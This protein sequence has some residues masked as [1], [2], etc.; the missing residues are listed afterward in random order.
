MFTSRAEYRL[1]LRHDNA[2][3]RLTPLGRRIG[4]VGDRAWDRLQAKEKAI[5]EV[6]E[7]LRTHR[8]GPDSL[9]R[10]LRR[11]EVEWTDLCAWVPA[12]AAMKLAADIVEQ[13]VL[14]LKYSGYIDRQAAQ[15]E[16]F[17]RLESR[18]IPA[19]FDYDAI[20]QLRFEAREKL[21]RIRP[22][23]VGQASRISGI[24]AADLAVILM[25]LKN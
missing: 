4:L 20:P 10:W 22:L 11:T 15:V 13:V 24:H 8:H 21:S 6:M 19:S 5:A 16:R 23:N 3:R 2:D 12:L 14:E 7:Y 18:P 1:L 9:E 17:H 25:Y